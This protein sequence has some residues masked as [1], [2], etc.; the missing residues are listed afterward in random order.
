MTPERWR[1]IADIY[2]AAL[3]RAEDRR[4]AF[5]AEACAGN[6][7]LRCEVLSLLQYAT[8][9][10]TFLM[11][12]ADMAAVDAAP[13]AAIQI[14]TELGSYRVHSL[15]GRGGMGTV[16]TAYDPRLQR[17]VAIK[18]LPDAFASNPAWLQRFEREARA[19]AALSHPNI[20]AVYDV[21]QH[22]GRPYI[23]MELVPGE[24]L[25]THLL[26]ERM[27][28]ARSLE[29]GAEI[30]DALAAA[31]ANG[32]L[33]R[34][35]KPA[36]VMM[37]PNG[38]VK[39]L[40]F[41]LAKMLASE[42]A[43]ANDTATRT[44]PGRLL[45]TPAYMA[46]ERLRGQP[47]DHRADIF[48]LGVIVFEL[49]T[50]RRPF[51]GSD[52]V[53][54]IANVITQVPP[55]A[56]E[57]EPAVPGQV[58]ELVAQILSKEP[59]TRPSAASL[60][61]T[62]FDRLRRELTTLTPSN[63]VT[64]TAAPRRSLLY[65]RRF[66]YATGAAAALAT[67][68]FVGYL[69]TGPSAGSLASHRQVTFA[70]DAKH[71]AI[72]RD[73]QFL[74]YISGREGAQ[75]VIVH[76]L[77]SGHSR[78]ALKGQQFFEVRWSPDDASILV[79][80][81]PGPEGLSLIP[82]LGGIPRHLPGRYR[83]AWSPDG[84]QIVSVDQGATSGLYFTDVKVGTTRFA[85]LKG[86]F[87]FLLQVDW[88][89]SGQWLLLIAA[90]Q[91]RKSSLWIVKPDGT[92]QQKLHEEVTGGLRA[93]WGPAG[94]VI[95]YMRGEPT[96]ELWKLTLV[97]QTGQPRRGPVLL[98]T[99]LD[100]ASWGAAS[101]LFDV[102]R[103]G[104][105]LAYT[106][107]S[108]YANLWIGQLP[109]E[110]ANQNLEP[111][112]LSSGTLTHH[113][114]RISPD[115]T[116]F[117]F[118]RGDSN[119]TNIFVLPIEGGAPRQL[120]FLNSQN[121]G[122][123]WSADGRT[124]AFASTEGGAAKVWTVAA[125]G[126]APPR[127]IATASV[128]PHSFAL[129]WAP[130]SNILY[131]HPSHRNFSILDPVT[132]STVPLLHDEKTGWIFRPRYSP[133]GKEI[134]ATWNRGGR[135]GLYVLSLQASPVD[136]ERPYRLVAGKPAF[137]TF[138]GIIQ[139]ANATAYRGKEFKLTAH[140]KTRVT[141]EGNVGQCWARVDRSGKQRGFFDNMDNRPI[142]SPTWGAFDIVGKFDDDAEQIAFGCFLSGFGE[143]WVDELELFFKDR[144]D[145]WTPIEIKNAGFEADS[146]GGQPSAWR[147]SSRGYTYQIRGDNPFR[148]QKSLVISAPVPPIS[149]NE[150]WP[151]SWS[152]DGRS[153]FAF[154]FAFSEIATIPATPGVASSY[155][156]FAASQDGKVSDATITPDGRHVVYS[157]VESHSD[158]WI[159]ENFDP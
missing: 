36:N 2:H 35:L 97:P 154:D 103:D 93:R 62:E 24:T 51:E 12:P 41:G 69:F 148:G 156:K 38:R 120:S 110:G 68:A 60:L 42:D 25:A 57:V 27:S 150:Y 118:S 75:T 89:P 72:S 7:E 101:E 140:V 74:A 78:D 20:L 26:R 88:S 129:E 142:V 119:V 144:A 115:G 65:G 117:A 107:S 91:A 135:L 52:L 90:D 153:I 85:A 146:V 66:V 114:P 46:P 9:P 151:I 95:Y 49:L 130:G 100:V 116:R 125:D 141:G 111:K 73:G 59:S 15:L 71:P 133:D 109:I 157:L 145:V 70:G 112:P 86:P 45:G 1:E 54:L 127:M 61:K 159:V 8:V 10:D 149:P 31:H 113:D 137:G 122:P 77:T 63:V 138:G 47:G 94:D 106:R 17:T 79:T 104:K 123:V 132:G 37:T 82:R 143:L 3:E 33:H 18:V 55:L 126:G 48:S 134:A 14:G 136:N 147:A 108:G 84:S 58:S 44:Q 29:I 4:A 98:L 83:A 28:V 131:Q 50:G 5:V 19:A 23:V 105:R 56:S 40:D 53:A 32:V 11:P 92:Q 158:V 152:A 81:R 124:I 30:A 96:Q 34:D 13:S 155:A 139:G 43:P 21:G 99:G 121:R 80:G 102:F 64:A 128:S 39:V 76:D 6:D 67:A 22:H 16:Y 87:E